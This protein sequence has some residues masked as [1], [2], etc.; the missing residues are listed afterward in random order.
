MC[1][2]LKAAQYM[3]TTLGNVTYLLKSLFCYLHMLQKTEILKRALWRTD[4][5]YF[6]S[7]S[8]VFFLNE[9]ILV[10]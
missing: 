8:L 9:T 1:I 2:V 4:Y 3:L 10:F 6:K 5:H 7:C